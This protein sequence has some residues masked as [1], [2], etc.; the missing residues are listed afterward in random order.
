VRIPMVRAERSPCIRRCAGCLGHD[1]EEQPLRRSN[2][3]TAI[4]ALQRT[5]GNAFV[6]RRLAAVARAAS[7]EEEDPADRDRARGV[8]PGQRPPG[9]RPEG[10]VPDLAK[11]ACGT[12]E[13]RG[14]QR[15]LE[16]Y[17]EHIQDS[18]HYVAHQL[19][20]RSGA[21]CD[22]EQGGGFS[23]RLQDLLAGL[24]RVP[25]GQGTFDDVWTDGVRAGIVYGVGR[26]PDGAISYTV[27]V[28]ESCR[29]ESTTVNGGRLY[30]KG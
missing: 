27:A 4:A 7:K 11:P 23:V 19:E 14:E 26:K 13:K 24:T 8:E 28:F 5:H 1:P 29:E 20:I 2:R 12:S 16:F 22:P 18:A 9:Y 30:R 10:P 15:S 25:W 3:E 17:P 21:T 6:A